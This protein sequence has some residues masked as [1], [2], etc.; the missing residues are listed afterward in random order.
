MR[1]I[2]DHTSCVC[3]NDNGYIKVYDQNGNVITDL[4]GDIVCMDSNNPCVT[5]NA[6]NR[7]F[8][9]YYE[10]ATM[11]KPAFLNVLNVDATVRNWIKRW[12]FVSVW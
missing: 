2:Y 10:N 8:N 5:L 3:D 4:R 9:Y 6:L 12:L 1:N 7:D 11:D